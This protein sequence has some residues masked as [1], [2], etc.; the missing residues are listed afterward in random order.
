[1]AVVNEL[2]QLA[3]ETNETILWEN[4]NIT[5]SFSPSTIQL[6]DNISNYDIL[7]IYYNLGTS[8]GTLHTQYIDYDCSNINEYATN[9]YR[10]MTGV[11]YNDATYTRNYNIQTNLTSIGIGGSARIN[12]TGYNNSTNIPVKICGLKK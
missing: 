9:K 12:A 7:R 10:I 11:V 8:I 2:P 5:T 4:Q 6:S 3:Q 1:M